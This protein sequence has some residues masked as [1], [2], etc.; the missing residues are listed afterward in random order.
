M[1]YAIRP[2]RVTVNLKEMIHA[3]CEILFI[4]FIYECNLTPRNL[5]QLH[6]PGDPDIWKRPQARKPCS[7][8]DRL[9]M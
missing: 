8:C 3:G 2:C 9:S 5:Q 6:N 4:I 1:L 7:C